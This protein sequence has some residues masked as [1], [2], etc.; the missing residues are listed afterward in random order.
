MRNRKVAARVVRSCPGLR[1]ARSIIDVGCGDCL[2]TRE[3][4]RLLKRR[5]SAVD[6]FD[7]RKVPYED[8]LVYDGRCLPFDDSKFDAALVLF[9]IHHT[10]DQLALLSEVA[11]VT[12]GSIVVFEDTY[13]SSF[14]RKF[15]E[16]YDWF[17]NR[18]ISSYQD[19]PLPLS[20]RTH[21]GWLSVFR[22]AGLRPVRMFA[23]RYWF[24]PFTYRMYVLEKI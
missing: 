11:R 17:S 15:L 12:S 2:L 4:S 23:K 3:L 20:F 9:T 14:Q 22:K 16:F 13:S 18:H 7:H 24:L 19:M 10:D 21:K 5:I 6:V 8:H 1:K